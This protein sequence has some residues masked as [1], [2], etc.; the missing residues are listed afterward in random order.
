MEEG[1]NGGPMTLSAFLIVEDLTAKDRDSPPY[2][3]IPHDL[4]P[5]VVH[6]GRR[7]KAGC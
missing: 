7:R 2:P 1:G 4:S 6:E 5:L 3:T